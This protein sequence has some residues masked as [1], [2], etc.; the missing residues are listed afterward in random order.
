MSSYADLVQAVANYYGRDSDIFTQ[1]VSTGGTGSA[2]RTADYAAA[3]QQIPGVSTVVNQSGDILYYEYAATEAVSSSAGSLVHAANSNVAGTAVATQVSVPVNATS[4]SAAAGSTITAAKS[5]VATAGNFA[6]REVLPAVAAA[7]AGI[8]LGKWID[9]AL[10]NANPNFWD[11]NGM[12]ALNPETWGS[13]TSGDDSLNSRLFNMIFGI[14]SDGAMQSY[15]SEDGFAYLAAY[16]Q[17]MGVFN[18]GDVQ[19]SM[20]G[21]TG[22]Y[23]NY[24]DRFGIDSFV[25]Q[26][27]PMRIFPYEDGRYQ[28]L[29]DVV[30]LWYT[31]EVRN[32]GLYWRGV[33][34]SKDNSNIKYKEYR[35]DGTQTSSGTLPMTATTRN[36]ITYYTYTWTQANYSPFLYSYN[37]PISTYSSVNAWDAAHVYYTGADI[38]QGGID[39]IETQP[40][41]TVPDLTGVDDL[42]DID[43]VK[44]ALQEQFPDLW[45]NAIQNNVPQNDGSTNTY[46]YIPVGFPQIDPSKPTQPTAISGLQNDLKYDPE[47]DPDGEIS[48]GLMPI[49]DFD[50]EPKPDGDPELSPIT[51]TPNPTDTGEGVTPPIIVPDGS[52]SALFAVYNP[53]QAQI[54]SF[55]AWLWSNDFVEQLKKIFN[56][57]M[58]SIIS[59]HK[60]FATPSTGSAQNIYVGY[61]NSGVSSATVTNQYVTVDCGTVDLLET[62]GNVFDYPPYTVIDL[63]LPFIGIVKLDNADVMRGKIHV[64]YRVDVLTGACLAQVEVTRDLSGGILYQYSGNCAVHYPVSAGSYV[65]LVGGVLSATLGAVGTFATGGALAPALLGGAG[66]AMSAHTDVSKSGGFT[67]NSG[68]MGGKKPYLIISRPQ[69][70]LADT[71]L[72]LEGVSS[73]QSVTL[74]S[75]TGL[76]K[77][78][79]VQLKNINA[80]LDELT[81]IETLLKG[82]VII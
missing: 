5:G 82:G 65:G 23:Y 61:L 9:S 33:C 70:A 72:S 13:I 77:V 27:T 22:L 57:P 53:T 17:Y 71:Y 58:E 40:G 73:N 11:S 4:T 69:T 68:A 55:G 28:V 3:M 41:A 39:G 50:I 14:D 16:M 66:A 43:A 24:E 78:K 10:Y 18:R 67:A 56:D 80:T 74:S 47:N 76:V 49:F 45:N 29:E 30:F 51:P 1:L 2:I 31:P 37:A 63:F 42:T 81:E 21:V 79:E 59:L 19:H 7:S 48:E 60:I 46:T 20:D 25:Y 8:S 52:V 35:A 15:L 62:F 64:V 34:F 12:G 6:M 26:P 36:G 38:S 75:C 32:Y 44:E 54:D